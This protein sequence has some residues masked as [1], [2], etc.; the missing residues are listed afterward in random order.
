M[1]F[2][3]IVQGS[4][5]D[6]YEIIVRDCP[7]SVSCSCPAGINR[8]PCKHRRAIL[9]GEDPGIIKGPKNKLSEISKSAKDSGYY[10][11]DS[12]YEILRDSQRKQHKQIEA[13]FKKYIEKRVSLS[14]AEIKTDA[15]VSKARTVVE[16]LIDSLIETEKK[17]LD[18]SIHLFN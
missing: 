3:F 2:S 18:I 16:G 4:A 12:E 1:D 6:P 10:D 14:L 13:A 17:I 5:L 8:I 9:N 7:F 15:P 11:K